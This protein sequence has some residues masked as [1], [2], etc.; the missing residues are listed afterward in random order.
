ML[1]SF[2]TLA[3]GAALAEAGASSIALTAASRD[4]ILRVTLRGYTQF[5]QKAALHKQNK[6][7]PPR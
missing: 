2:E 5:V 3:Y 1:R 7:M 6:G 4:Q